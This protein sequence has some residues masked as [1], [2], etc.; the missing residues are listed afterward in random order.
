MGPASLAPDQVR[1][2]KKADELQFTA[3]DTV[4]GTAEKW[5]ASLAAILGLFGTVLLVKGRE[6][7][8]KLADEYQVA[9][10]MVLLMA[11]AAAAGA[12]AYAAFAA[13][14]TP[15]DLRW[16]T[17]DK[18]RALERASAVLARER[19]KWSRILTFVAVGLLAAAVGLTWF[20]EAKPP[21]STEAHL[22]VIS[23]SAD[24]ECGSLARA[25]GGGLVL[26][27]DAS[28]QVPIDPADVTSA[29]VVPSCPSP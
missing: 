24:P 10:A 27:T 18:L 17:G 21:E 1:W 16:P 23:P 20:G 25:A 12:S 11:L 2:Q 8:T 4:R 3:L 6:D 19:L 13:Q 28:T 5:A 14:G 29:V 7:I 26:E 22:L 9:V 15:R